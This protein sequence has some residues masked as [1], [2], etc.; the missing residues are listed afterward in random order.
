M[1]A[2]LTLIVAGLH[3]VKLFVIAVLARGQWRLLCCIPFLLNNYSSRGLNALDSLLRV[4]F[5]CQFEFLA[6]AKV[7]LWSRVLDHAS[8]TAPP[9]SISHQVFSRSTA[10]PPSP[11]PVLLLL[12]L[13]LLL[14]LLLLLLLLLRG[15]GGGGGGGGGVLLLY[16]LDLAL[17]GC[18]HS[19]TCLERVGWSLVGGGGHKSTGGG[20]TE[21]KGKPCAL[22]VAARRGQGRRERRKERRRDERKRS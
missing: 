14:P 17:S 22:R 13:L 18:D 5:L 19:S 16:F 9:L 1:V 20:G 3:C 2:V 7:G 10:L 12:L 4:L 6:I 15:G 21:G 8:S 11:C